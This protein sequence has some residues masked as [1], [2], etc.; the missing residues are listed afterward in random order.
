[1]FR[2]LRL[3]AARIYAGGLVRVIGERQDIWPLLAGEEEE[4]PTE[5]GHLSTVEEIEPVDCLVRPVKR[6]FRMLCFAV[7]MVV[8]FSVFGQVYVSEFLNYHGAGGW[9]NQPLIQL[10]WFRY[11]S[12]HLREKGTTG[13]RKLIERS[14]GSPEDPSSPI[15]RRT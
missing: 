11:V 1:L 4:L 14:N 9:L 13:K 12:S 6:T 10:P 7:T 3:L 8:W 2:V 15:R 5:L